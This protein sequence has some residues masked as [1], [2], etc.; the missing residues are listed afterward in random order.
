[1]GV[2]AG[3]YA[4]RGCMYRQVG[5]MRKCNVCYMMRYANMQDGQV[6]AM[7]QAKP[8]ERAKMGLKGLKIWV[9]GTYYM[10]GFESVL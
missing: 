10:T 6:C 5:A 3:V 2:Y 7:Q 9:L 1:M 4:M 8:A